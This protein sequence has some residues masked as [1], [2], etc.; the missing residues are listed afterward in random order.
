MCTNENAAIA[1]FRALQGNK[2]VIVG[3]RAKGDRGERYL[4]LLIKEA[5]A[6]VILGD[7]A[8]DIA[9][10]FKN[11][12]FTRFAIARDMDEAIRKSKE[13]AAVGDVILLNPGYASFGLFIDF[14]ARGDAFRD[15][16]RK[17]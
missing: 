8:A 15:G 14:A 5:K 16:I 2:I 9:Q 11:R 6:C 7:N 17:N 13:Y 12:G 1:S 3:G 10:Y 4:D